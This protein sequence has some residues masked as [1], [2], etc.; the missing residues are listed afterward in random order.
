MPLGPPHPAIR[1]DLPPAL[2]HEPQQRMIRI[3]LLMVNMT[4]ILL[5]RMRCRNSLL[6]K[7]RGAVYKTL[8][9]NLICFPPVFS[10]FAAQSPKKHD[11]SPTAPTF[12]GFV[13]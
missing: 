7:G 6:F 10:S 12:R 2:G 4:C 9:P 13:A 1:F 8:Y 3:L 5:S 11:F